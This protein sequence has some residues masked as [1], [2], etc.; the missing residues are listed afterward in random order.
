MFH[1][2]IE[3]ESGPA[4]VVQVIEQARRSIVLNA[5]YLDDRQVLSALGAAVK[6]GVQVQVILDRKP[7]DMRPWRLRREFREVRATGAR[8][9]A[10]PPRFEFDHAKYVCSLSACEIG[11]ANYSWSA[12]HRNRE[13]MVVTDDPHIVKAA[14]RV[15]EADWVSAR[16][17]SMPRR[18]L[19]L[20]PGATSSLIKALAQPGPID[21]EQEELGDDSQLL[22]ALLAKGRMARLILPLRAARRDRERVARLRR[23]GVQIKFM[24]RRVVYM[25][26]KMIVGHQLAFIGSQNMSWTSL[27]RNREM[28]VLFSHKEALKTLESQFNADWKQAQSG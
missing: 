15:F 16:A 5:Y 27:N 11:T 20:S 18:Y 13:Y 22:Q 10:S 14:R 1:I 23:A 28:G 3:P 19:V 17:G 6:R 4:P 24:S 12:F 26:A 21:I 8:V 7:Y 25:H 2:Y 9:K